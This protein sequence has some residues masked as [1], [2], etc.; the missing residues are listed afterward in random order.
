[1]IDI[2]V[3][4]KNSFFNVMST[5][6]TEI[7]ENNVNIAIMIA[8]ISEWIVPIIFIIAGLSGKPKNPTFS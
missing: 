8:R 3:L 2:C 7:I 4:I 5:P 6:E 1:M